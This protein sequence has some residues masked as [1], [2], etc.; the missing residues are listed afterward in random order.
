MNQKELDKKLELHKLWLEDKEGGVR[1]DL[2]NANLQGTNLQDA[3][4]QYADLQG[5]NLQRANLQYADLQGANL[6][7]ANLQRANL[8]GANLQ[9]ADLQDARLEGVI[10][11]QDAA[12]VV[13]DFKRWGLLGFLFSDE[14]ERGQ[15]VFCVFDD[16]IISLERA[17]EI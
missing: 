8:Q 7:F 14:G 15:K 17:L 12:V 10:N 5:A 3:D 13:S 6:Q 1:L 4:L 16:P 9:N 2:Q 11:L